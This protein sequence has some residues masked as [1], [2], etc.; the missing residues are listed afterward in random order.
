[1]RLGGGG[2]AFGGAGAGW[3]GEDG[4]YLLS[5]PPVPGIPAARPQETRSLLCSTF[6]A[7]LWLRR[8]PIGLRQSLRGVSE[9]NRPTAPE[10][11]GTGPRPARRWLFAESL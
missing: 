7:R 1:G 9:K 5:Q 4:R 8:R 2:W 11:I 6:D 3:G 10:S